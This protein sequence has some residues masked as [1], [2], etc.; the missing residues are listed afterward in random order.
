MHNH[1]VTPIKR[2]DMKLN[3]IQAILIMASIFLFYLSLVLTTSC[4]PNFKIKVTNSTNIPL[5]LA[6]SYEP[7]TGGEYPIGNVAPGSTLVSNNKFPF[8]LGAVDAIIINGK[9]QG[10]SLI[11]S[12]RFSR[13]EW[14]EMGQKLTI[15]QT[16]LIV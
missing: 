1:D 12:E 5:T 11:Y 13:T 15:A 4:E 2:C 7:S 8:P 10:G 16:D 14:I 3:V 6:V 9:N